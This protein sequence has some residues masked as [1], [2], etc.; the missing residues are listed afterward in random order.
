MSGVSVGLVQCNR[1]AGQFV[2]VSRIASNADGRFA[3][4]NVHPNDEYFVYTTMGDVSA[5]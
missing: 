5:S 1:G 3:F 2:G 4:F